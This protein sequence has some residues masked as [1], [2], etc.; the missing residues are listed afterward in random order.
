[1]RTFLNMPLK[2][3]QLYVRLDE[4]ILTEPP[5]IEFECMRR[6][7]GDEAMLWGA[8]ETGCPTLNAAEYYPQFLKDIERTWATKGVR[9]PRHQ[10]HVHPN[11][12]V[13][14]GNFRGHWWRWAG[15]EFLPIN[16]N[17]MVCNTSDLWGAMY[18]AD[19]KNMQGKAETTFERPRHIDYEGESNWWELEARHFMKGKIKRGPPDKLFNLSYET[20]KARLEA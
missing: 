8:K 13:G 4:L 2:T 14:D 16:L 7:F 1:M 5:V 18:P 12:I 11:G 6:Q 17:Y 10:L 19:G 9:A 15:L 20:C 3:I